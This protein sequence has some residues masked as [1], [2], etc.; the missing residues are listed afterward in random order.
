[1][2][3]KRNAQVNIE[4]VLNYEMLNIPTNSVIVFIIP[5]NETYYYWKKYFKSYLGLFVL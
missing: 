2:H 5:D 3:K 4:A 1:M